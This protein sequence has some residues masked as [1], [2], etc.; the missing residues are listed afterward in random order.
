MENCNPQIINKDIFATK[1]FEFIDKEVLST[2]CK[3]INRATCELIL[4]ALSK[5]DY[6]TADQLLDVL[7]LNK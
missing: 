6:K 1:D 3:C 2:K 7:K 5:K 4:I